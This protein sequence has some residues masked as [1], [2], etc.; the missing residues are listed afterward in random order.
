MGIHSL[1][2]GFVKLSY[3]GNGHAHVMVQP[4]LPSISGAT[5]ALEKV[6]GGTYDPWTDAIDAFNVLFKACLNTSDGI[7][8]AE[9][10]TL[11]S[12]SADPIFRESYASVVAGTSGT[13]ALPMAQIE[14]PHRTAD[15]G[16]YR[17]LMMEFAGSNSNFVDRPPIASNA[18][19]AVSDFL[20][21]STG[22]VF[23]RD[24][25]APV[26]C[27]GQF[28]KINDALRKKYLLNV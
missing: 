24:G 1:Y 16:I 5:W 11:A 6:L 26:F 15:G 17:L 14:M 3:T 20:I 21:A 4:V 12:E 22:Y 18:F 10:W 8:G 23:G 27:T 2:P 7:V 9:L 13:A 19:K 25:S 28:G